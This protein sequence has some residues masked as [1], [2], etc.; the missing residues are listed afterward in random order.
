MKTR[1]AALL[2]ALTLAAPARA[3]DL[4]GDGVAKSL[5]ATTWRL[6]VWS[7]GTVI[8]TPI[9]VLRKTFDN[10]VETTQNLAG[11][12]NPALKYTSPLVGLPVGIFT[13]SLEGLW[14][15]PSNS[16]EN[17]VEKPF[18]KELISLGELKD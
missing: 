15:G 3:D 16:W 5:G 13:G 10:T 12:D 6:A 9:A 14:L 8:G 2:F 17:S 1:L 7:C 11:K 4:N 18:S